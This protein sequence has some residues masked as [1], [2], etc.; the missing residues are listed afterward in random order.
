MTRPAYNGAAGRCDPGM[1]RRMWA[2]IVKEFVQMRR[3]RM[4]FATMLFVPVLQLTLFG[5]AI[6]FNPK[7]LPT[8]VSIADPG[9][10]SRSIIAAMRNSSYFDLIAETRSPSQARKLLQDGK[11][12]FVVE[13]PEN[14]SRDLVRGAQPDLLMDQS[15]DNFQ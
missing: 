6:N 3:D 10:F 9:I 14:F 2:M 15:R 8:A 13:V 4:T 11:V 12:L 1:F 7:A 5:F